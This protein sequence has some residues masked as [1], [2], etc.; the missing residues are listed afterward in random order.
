M[1]YL[2]ETCPHYKSIAQRL[3]RNMETL[4]RKFLEDYEFGI[5]KKRVEYIFPHE[6]L[7]DSDFFPLSSALV[8]NIPGDSYHGRFEVDCSFFD[9]CRSF[10]GVV[11]VFVIDTAQFEWNRG[12]TYQMS[13]PKPVKG[14]IWYKAALTPIC[15]VWDPTDSLIGDSGKAAY[16]FGGYYERVASTP[17][18]AFCR[19]VGTLRFEK[20][21]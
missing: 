21:S 12:T 9:K 14:K 2:S 13:P 3:P 8:F 10:A 11:G 1:F 7:S 20:Q 17:P 5:T 15:H 18:G 19:D 4:V 6:P 16:S